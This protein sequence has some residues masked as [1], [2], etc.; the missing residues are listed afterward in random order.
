[1]R[2]H[3]DGRPLEVSLTV[4]PI[5]DAEGTII[6]ASEIAQDVTERRRAERRLADSEE[7]YRT[8]FEAIDEGFCV[9]EKVDTKPGALS[10]FR[11]MVANPSFATQAGV[12][13]V[14]GKTIREA[15]PGEPQEWFDTYDAVLRTGEPIRFERELS[16]Q[17][18]VLEL[19]AFRLD[20]G[21]QRRVAVIFADI[22]ARK[23]AEMHQ[24]LL[25][26]ELNHRVKNTLAAVQSIAAQSMKGALDI[27]Q[28]KDFEARLVALARTHDLLSE[29]SWANA[30][31]RDV[32]MLEL[33]PYRFE[34]GKRF[35]V[36]GPD[37][38]V[39]P[40]AALAI[41]MAFH[42]LATNAA[43]YGALSKFTGQVHVAWN[44]LSAS[45]PIAI[46]LKWTESGG[47]PVTR[48][49]R[50]GFGS[51]VIERGLSLELDAEVHIEFN[52]GGLVCTMIIPLACAGGGG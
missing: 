25:V 13:N 14:V 41:G 7:R 40:K 5:K 39:N 32:L 19:Y 37:L 23:R 10:D 20:D 34:E 17:G 27:E 38:M 28:R 45:E 47:P 44:I 11:Y 9:I 42:E 26:N 18:R 12:G 1:V 4:S 3:K 51:T 43:K 6:G 15:F 31:L 35:V 21:T 49:G 2:Q 52:P 33:E 46:R 36:E 22:T 8:L 30:S 29:G 50:K 16:T 24:E 48:T